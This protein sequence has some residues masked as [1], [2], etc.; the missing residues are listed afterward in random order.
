MSIEYMSEFL[1]IDLCFVIYLWDL[2][3]ALELSMGCFYS[4]LGIY[5]HPYAHLI[6]VA[7]VYLSVLHDEWRLG[8]GVLVLCNFNNIVT[9]A[10]MILGSTSEWGNT[11]L[12]KWTAGL[13][14]PSSD[15]EPCGD[16]SDTFSSHADN[17]SSASIPV[18]NR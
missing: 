3:V 17:T 10:V 15:V 18:T 2:C 1:A 5:C 8:F 13:A 4:S 16:D 7:D 14:K 12:K 6:V 11:N 9:E